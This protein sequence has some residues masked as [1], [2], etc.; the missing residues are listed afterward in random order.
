MND[1]I[2]DLRFAIDA[3]LGEVRPG[4]TGWASFQIVNRQSS[5]PNP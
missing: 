5:I 4:Q 3:L 1:P 2:Y